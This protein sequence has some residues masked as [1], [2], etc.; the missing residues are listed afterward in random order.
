MGLGVPTLILIV[1]KSLERKSVVVRFLRGL[2]K[3]KARRDLKNF[4]LDL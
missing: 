2:I 3:K 4:R 1:K